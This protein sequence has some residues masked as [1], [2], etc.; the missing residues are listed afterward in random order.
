MFSNEYSDFGVGTCTSRVHFFMNWYSKLYVFIDLN[1]FDIDKKVLSKG[2][3]VFAKELLAIEDIPFV[4]IL[5]SDTIVA[6][7]YGFEDNSAHERDVHYFHFD[8]YGGDGL[9]NTALYSDIVVCYLLSKRVYLG[10]DPSYY[11]IS[12]DYT[13]INTIDG[14]TSI[15]IRLR[16]ISS[17][18]YRNFKMKYLKESSFTTSE[19]IALRVGSNTLRECDMD[20]VTD[21]V[22]TLTIED[23]DDSYEIQGD[24]LRTPLIDHY[25]QQGTLY[26][27]YMLSG[28]HMKI[29]CSRLSQRM[30]FHD[31]TV[32]R[33]LDSDIVHFAYSK[34]KLTAGITS[35]KKNLYNTF[36]DDNT[37]EYI[38]FRLI[39]CDFIIAFEPV[40]VPLVGVP[41]YCEINKYSSKL[42]CKKYLLFLL[43]DDLYNKMVVIDHLTKSR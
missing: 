20:R 22:V 34:D 33:L 29:W 43:V 4:L 5:Y 18:F 23:I 1:S 3:V 17:L 26:D 11:V 27:D 35:I 13:L 19:A 2:I 28:L 31:D 9:V 36:I 14:L 30:G 15:D 8:N 25:F 12:N 6:H 16:V 42:L 37:E 41:T 21:D 24:T 38:L 7:N 32:I 40:S 39:Q 10:S